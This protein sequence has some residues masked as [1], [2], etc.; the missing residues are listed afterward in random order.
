MKNPFKI[1]TR[2]ELG[3]WIS[4][5]I[6]VILSSVFSE[7]FNIVS[8]LSSL[9]GVTSLIFLAR[10]HILGQALMIAFSILYSIVS[11]SQGYY[12]EMMTYLGMTTPMAVFCIISWLR[13]P[14]GKTGEVR[15]SV[16]TPRKLTAALLLT[17]AV[18]VSFY[19]ILG[20][21]NTENLIVSTFSVAT[22]FFAASLTFLRSPYF[23]LGY[24][25]NDVVI[26]TLWIIAAIKDPSAYSVAAC[27]IAFLVNDLYGFISWRRMKARQAAEDLY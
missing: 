2:F 9:V 24:A 4:S 23:P 16:L 27:F 25:L 10:G 5:C 6:V 15:V 20:L 3:L 14:Y 1:L 17:L 21:L 7:S 18:T 8:L 11:Y 22:S 19:F 13:N 12:G 26:I